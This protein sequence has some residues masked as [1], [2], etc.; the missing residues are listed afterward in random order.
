MHNFIA[1]DI[2]YINIVKEAFSLGLIV[3]FHAGLD[4]GFPGVDYS[5]YKRTVSL[6]DKLDLNKG[7]LILAHMGSL[8]ELNES[9]EYILSRN[10]YIDT[11]MCIGTIHDMD[12]GFIDINNKELILKMIKK[13][14]SEKVL[15]GSDNPW[16]DAL[17]MVD[18]INSLPLREEEKQ[19]IFY[20]N[21]CRLLSI[22]EE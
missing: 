10:V 3:L 21:A 12:K 17:S 9:Y 15:F 7:V 18:A 14:G 5:S 4:P 22:K 2:K 6:L 11:A 19:N 16:I 8:D 13:H 20:K 1:I